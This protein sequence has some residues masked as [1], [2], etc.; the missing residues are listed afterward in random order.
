[1][2]RINIRQKVLILIKKLSSA[3]AEE[4]ARVLHVSQATARYHLAGL[5]IDGSVEVSLLMNG[6]GR[7]QK[8]YRPSRLSRDDGLDYLMDAFL[9]TVE[10]ARQEQVWAESATRLAAGSNAEAE[11]IPVKRF[12]LAIEHLNQLKYEA[13]WEAHAGGPQVILGNC[14][15]F[16]VIENQPGLCRMDARL[17]EKLFGASVEHVAKLEMD[18]RGLPQCIFKL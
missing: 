16:R 7:P 15:Y 17:L 12:G 10:P 18:R 8:L 11:K 13:R 14:P 3:T 2:A 4:V 5:A 9:A 6:R 1:M